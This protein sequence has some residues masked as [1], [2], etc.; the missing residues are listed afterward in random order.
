M[1]SNLFRSLGTATHNIPCSAIKQSSRG[2]GSG[3]IISNSV[4]KPKIRKYAVETGRRLR[5]SK[6]LSWLLRH[7]GRL[8]GIHIR[9]DGYARIQDVVSSQLKHQS[10]RNVEFLDIE[11]VIKKDSKGRFTLTYEGDRSEG[12][13]WW[14]RANQGHSIEAADLELERIGSADR[15]P[16]AVHGTTEEAW[17]LISKQGISRMTRN[18]IHLAQGFAEGVDPKVFSG[19]RKSSRILIYI[20]VEKALADG[21]KFYLSAN[22]VVLCPG[23]EYGFL[24]PKYFQRV[25][26]VTK[27]LE[28][29]QEWDRQVAETSSTIDP[30]EDRLKAWSQR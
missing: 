17:K 19:I 23:D 14:I 20:D 5:I 26:S 22:G 4:R 12:D 27:T 16:V 25:E 13:H 2:Y 24:E 11:N 28:P 21:I 29:M 9:S 3:T 10:M 1:F 15:I 6:S 7:Q 8:E 30:T 18:H